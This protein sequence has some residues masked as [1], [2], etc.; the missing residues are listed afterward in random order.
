M[1]KIKWFSVL[2]VMLF[3]YSCT[4]VLPV[5]EVETITIEIEK[6]ALNISLPEPLNLENIKLHIFE[7]DGKWYISY[8][9]EDYEKIADNMEQIQNYILEQ[10]L[11]IKQYKQYYEPKKN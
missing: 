11:I 8:I 10:N 6:P 1:N 5:R 2:V 3:I 4:S 7:Y 9:I